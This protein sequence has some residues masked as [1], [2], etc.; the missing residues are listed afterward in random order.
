MSTR[1]RRLSF[2]TALILA[3][4]CSRSGGEASA[5]ADEGASAIALV[6]RAVAVA[7]AIRTNPAAGDS[8]LAAHGLTRAAFDSLMYDV[9]ADSALA[10]AYAEA[11]R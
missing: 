8:I 11:I 10:R 7:L 1:F 6:D 2:G 5:A 4:A 3:A 9:A